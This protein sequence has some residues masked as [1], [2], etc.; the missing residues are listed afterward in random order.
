MMNELF[1]RDHAVGSQLS[2]VRDSWRE[3]YRGEPDI[4]IT[5]L[6]GTMNEWCGTIGKQ[7]AII[8]QQIEGTADGAGD[9][10]ILH[11]H[12]KSAYPALYDTMTRCSPP[13]TS[14]ETKVFL[15]IGLNISSNE[16]AI[17]LRCTRGAILKHRSRIRKKMRICREE[18]LELNIRS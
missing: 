5:R 3:D 9:W 15:L 8:V 4:S 6:L 16:S 17:L 2:K 14:T 18:K 1:D 13:L 7:L 11:R 10:E 12:V